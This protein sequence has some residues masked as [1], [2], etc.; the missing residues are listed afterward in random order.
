MRPLL[1]VNFH[2]RH[3]SGNLNFISSFFLLKLESLENSFKNMY[4]LH[5]IF[6]ISKDILKS[7]ENTA[8][9]N[10]F[11]TIIREIGLNVIEIYFLA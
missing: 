1:L 9:E 7:H 4:K 3:G 10:A 11:N 8:L 5:S 6:T 2:H